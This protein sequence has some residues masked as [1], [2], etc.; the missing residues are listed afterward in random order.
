M[1]RISV[2]GLEVDCI[3]GM[4]PPERRRRQRVILDLRLDLDLNRAGESG[5]I[6][7]TADYSKVADEVC[8][9]LRFRA[10]RLIEVATNEIASMLLGVHP[11]LQAVEVRLEKPAALRG[12]AKAASVSIVRHRQPYAMVTAS[13]GKRTTL[14][15]NREAGLYLFEVRPGSTL[16]PVGSDATRCLEWIVSGNADAERREGLLVFP[17]GRSFDFA[18]NGDRPA[19]LFCCACP[20]LE[21]SESHDRNLVPLHQ[22]PR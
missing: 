7:H 1:D 4:R 19:I 12:R 22:V 3:V 15:E 13:F 9:L 2:E 5:R 11:V 17:D 10:Y 20:H 6:A 16:P 14:S 21:V 8:M 18:N